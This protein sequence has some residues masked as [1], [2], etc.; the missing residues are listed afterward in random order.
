M[1]DTTG[2][3][4]G[5]MHMKCPVCKGKMITGKAIDYL[6]KNGEIDLNGLKK[7]GKKVISA[8]GEAFLRGSI[9][10]GVEMAIQN[11]IIGVNKIGYVPV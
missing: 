4:P 5:A 8:S 10:Y 1:T 7:S 9:A 6:I 11:G 2:D 3:D